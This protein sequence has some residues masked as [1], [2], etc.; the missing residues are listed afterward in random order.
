MRR[1]SSGAGISENCRI[2]MRALSG[3][4]HSGHSATE[5]ESEHGGSS[6]SPGQS[7]SGNLMDDPSTITAFKCPKTKKVSLMKR[8]LSFFRSVFH[9]EIFS[10]QV[11]FNNWSGDGG[12]M[13][14]GKGEPGDPQGGPNSLPLSLSVPVCYMRNPNPRSPTRPFRT[15][16][17]RPSTLASLKSSSAGSSSPDPH[18]E[19]AHSNDENS[20][21]A[22]LPGSGGPGG[23]AKKRWLRQ[24][25]SEETETES[26][27][28]GVGGSGGIGISSINATGDG[29][30]HVTPL[31]KR[32]L[33]RASMSSETSFTPPSTPTPSN[34]M[35][36][37]GMSESSAPNEHAAP[38]DEVAENS[39]STPPECDDATI[40]EGEPETSALAVASPRAPSSQ[41]AI[42]PFHDPASES[43]QPSW[44]VRTDESSQSS[45]A[46][47]VGAELPTTGG[48][49]DA[50]AVLLQPN[51]DS[52]AFS[53][54]SSRPT[55][56]FRAPDAQF[57]RQGNRVAGVEGSDQ[58]AAEAV[59]VA[60][61]DPVTESVPPKPQVKR[62]V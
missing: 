47:S 26:P 56:E 54:S 33:A 16:H 1:S 36:L 34:A 19:G 58:A 57:M 9:I 18:G 51:Y 14:G 28:S 53:P 25:I 46:P 15:A 59:S 17:L 60:T 37:P 12:E 11:V 39:Q 52:D 22:P 8:F 40:T 23:S 27:S 42:T 13:N 30:D 32:R 38:M 62:K 31:K 45:E 4:V 21:T 7:G 44:Y 2:R 41:E 35:V 48:F 29:L 24:A 49:V 10:F 43:S 6:S 50:T 20:W 61:T 5:E 55:W 3:E